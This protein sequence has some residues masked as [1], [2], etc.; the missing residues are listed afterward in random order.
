MKNIN[1]PKCLPSI[2][3]DFL[4]QPIY[5]AVINLPIADLLEG[6]YTSD[7]VLTLCK[8]LESKQEVIFDGIHL[9]KFWDDEPIQVARLIVDIGVGQDYFYHTWD[10]ITDNLKRQG[11]INDDED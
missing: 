9:Q 1:A 2:H 7:Q 10:F 4:S 5:Q 11:I 8:H 3:G 6:G